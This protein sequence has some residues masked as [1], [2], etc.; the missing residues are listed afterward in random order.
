MLRI[1]SV[2]SEIMSKCVANITTLDNLLDRINLEHYRGITYS[3]YGNLRINI[4]SFSFDDVP[5][6][7]VSNVFALCILNKQ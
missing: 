3:A 5:S 7:N 4:K 2:K 1:Y 6:Y